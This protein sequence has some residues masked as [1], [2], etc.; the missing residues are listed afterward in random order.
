MV[1]GKWAVTVL[2]IA[3]GLLAAFSLFPGEEKKVKKQFSLLAHHASKDEEE[4]ILAM[5]RKMKNLESLFAESCEVTAPPYS[6]AGSFSRA[7]LVNLIART[8]LNFSHLV[9]TFHDLSVSF[10]NRETAEVVLTGEVRG[11]SSRGAP[12][13]EVRE[14]ACLLKKHE[15]EW[16]FS[17]WATVEVLKR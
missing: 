16:L 13:Q 10:P 7:D 1:K 3:A 14:I 5:A 11:K 15:G 6:L 2:V 12:V 4:K 8:R 17:K 9:L